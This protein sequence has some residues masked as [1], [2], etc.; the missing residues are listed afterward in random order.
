M[1]YKPFNYWMICP[2]CGGQYRKSDMKEE[3][4]GLWVCSHG[5]YQ[6]RHPQDFVTSVEEDPSVPVVR[7]D[8]KQ[9]MGETTLS[10]SIS[11]WE[12]LAVLASVIGLSYG[13]PIGID[14]D[15]G[16]TH[17]SFVDDD[18]TLGGDVLVD[19]DAEIIYD[20]DGE[21]IYATDAV[22]PSS[23]TLNSPVAYKATLGNTVYLPSLNKETWV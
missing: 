20:R 3:W 5:C 23:V 11:Q 15:N 2:R 19:S 13:D 22:P 17:W 1:A 6:K 7:P 18:P 12:T 14:L 9:T 4:T 8:V 10:A 21:V 16:V